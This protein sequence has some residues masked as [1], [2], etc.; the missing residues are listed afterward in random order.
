MLFRSHATVSFLSASSYYHLLYCDRQQYL[1][2]R[3]A[4]F[5]PPFGS[6]FHLRRYSVGS[7]APWAIGSVINLYCHVTTYAKVHV[8]VNRLLFSHPMSYYLRYMVEQ[9]EPA[10]ITALYF[11][12][13]PHLTRDRSPSLPA[14]FASICTTLFAQILEIFVA[15]FLAEFPIMYLICIESTS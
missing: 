9:Y 7:Q 4:M 6:S 8:D 12:T 3:Q 14:S 1:Q 2:L 10:C 11:L 5:P 13:G 15:D